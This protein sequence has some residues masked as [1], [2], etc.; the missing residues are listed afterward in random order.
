MTKNRDDSEKSRFIKEADYQGWT[1]TFS[2]KTVLWDNDHDLLTTEAENVQK[3]I[4]KT[5]RC[6]G[7]S[8]GKSHT[9]IHDTS[10]DYVEVTRTP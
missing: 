6:C 10:P 5:D 7:N 1:N 3:P 9:R 4:Q 2:R 8:P